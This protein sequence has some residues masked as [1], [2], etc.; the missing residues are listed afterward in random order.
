[1]PLDIQRLIHEDRAYDF[2]V[3]E[4]NDAY[5]EYFNQLAGVCRQLLSYYRMENDENT[6]ETVVITAYL[7][8]LLYT[9]QALRMKFTYTPDINRAL[10]IDLTESGFPN[11]AEISNIS[12][13]LLSRESRLR[14]IPASAIF[15]RRGILD[16][17]LIRQED[18][19]M[20]LWQLSE[21][22][23]LEM[24]DQEK[25]FL[26]F[27]QGEIIRRREDAH[28]RSYVTSWAC[29]DFQTNCP[30]IHIL[31]FDQD[32]DVQ[33][34]EEEGETRLELLEVLRSEGS[35][36]PTVNILAMQIDDAIET[37][38]PKVLKRISL[39]PLYSRLLFEGY[40]AE[41]VVDPREPVMRELLMNYARR[42]EDFVLFFTQEIIFSQ[43]QDVR[44]S[45]FLRG[46][47]VREIFFIPDAGSA[48]YQY[49]ASVVHEQ[50]LL[51]HM[52]LQ[53]ISQ[54]AESQIQ[55]FAN[56]KKITYSEKGIINAI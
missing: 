41:S 42:R 53:H 39:G 15:L 7:Q 1:M 8:R 10:W 48:T 37:I 27:N 40:N 20:L 4:G 9:V 38:H 11:C 6:Y 2:G 34:I 26:T 13:D 35:R 45:T 25:L 22:T 19:N 32:T 17:L 43:R 23:Y 28:V 21:R 51:P 3:L 36:A 18:P 16:H 50:V 24:L 31:T 5:A 56:A 14:D 46:S 49:R 12:T 44:K 54:D 30:Y 47:R 52:L 29:Y 55:G 33:P